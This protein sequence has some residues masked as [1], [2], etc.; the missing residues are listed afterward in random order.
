MLSTSKPNRCGSYP[1]RYIAEDFGV[2]YGVVL[3]VADAFATD[4]NVNFDDACEVFWSLDEAR[5]KE[6]FAHVRQAV[7]A[8][9]NK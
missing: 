6:F 8:R 9:V 1:F 5:I 4:E 7:E 2:D 3:R